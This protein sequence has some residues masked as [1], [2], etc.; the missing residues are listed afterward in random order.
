MVEAAISEDMLEAMKAKAGLALRIEHSVNNEEATRLAIAKFSAGIGDD[1]PLWT[2]PDYAAA[3][4]FGGVVAPPS[5]VIGVF[6]GLQF[7][8]PGLGS[9]HAHSDLE[10]HLPVRLGDKVRAEC[11]YEGFDGPKSS[12]F[13]RTMVVDN[14]TNR[15][16]NQHGE[17]V[18]EIG[19]SVI[20]FE[21]GQARKGGRDRD[22]ELPHRWTEA[23]LSAME[24]E[25]LA[26]RPRGAEPRWWEDVEVGESL[27]RILKGPIGMT[28]EV[29]FV[30]GGGAPIPRLSA[31]GVA[32]RSYRHHP[33][34]AFRDPETSALE[35]IYSVHYNKHA[36]RAMGV[37]LQYDVGFQRQCWQL[38]LLTNWMSD[39]GWVKQ[40]R[41]EYRKFVYHGDAVRLGGTVERKYLD[42]DGE[43]C[44]DITTEAVNQ[45]GDD[46]MPG[47]ATLALPSRDMGIEPL[48]RRS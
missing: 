9:F 44:V 28:D 34:W 47:T 10:F 26:E 30:A 13:A 8:W 6:S 4:P 41:A 7:G 32:L 46:V 35:P 20:N 37:A 17:L 14:F 27:D 33:A 31:H 39:T 43:A 36:A 15:Y 29:A 1:N 16:W 3:G 23:E 22:I 18:A 12:S 21:R 5:F 19:W 38:Q 40:A 48:A 25:V 2:D 24:D 11:V 45:R 42:G